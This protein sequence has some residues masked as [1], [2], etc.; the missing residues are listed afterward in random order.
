MM[1]F[2][3]NLLV[4]LVVD[5]LAQGSLY[6]SLAL[7]IVLVHQSSG[8]IN[9]SQG[10]LAVLGAYIGMSVGGVAT[11]IVGAPVGIAFGVVGGLFFAFVIGAL[12]ERVIMR[13]FA[14]SEEDTKVVVSVGLLLLLTGAIG[15]GWGYNFLPYPFYVSASGSFRLGDVSVSTWS[16]VTFI[17]IV[18]AM[19][20]IQILFRGTKLGLGLRAVA[21]NP[22]SAALSGVRVGRMLMIGWGLAAGLGTA[23][24]ILL[25]AKQQLSPNNFDP[26]LVYALAAVVIGG[27]DSPIGAVVA[28]WGIAILENLA[29]TYLSVVPGTDIQLIGQ[30]LKI[31][32]P[33][34]L[35]FII[36]VT[37]PQGLF[38]RK[39]VTRV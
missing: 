34:V 18:I 9:F 3:V 25:A 23:A 2:N 16:L 10:A 4:Q 7:A 22:A 38:G 30:D 26:I 8:M 24:G 1:D 35:V 5:G 37:R 20:V 31:I 11:P 12:L 17:T 33:F 6:A 27:L 21:D 15:V 36:L 39:L 13:R 32:V 19:I 29:A 28:A 14:G